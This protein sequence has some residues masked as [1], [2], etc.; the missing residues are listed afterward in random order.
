M[1]AP[2]ILSITIKFSPLVSPAYL[3]PELPPPFI[4]L[5][6]HETDQW[7]LHTIT[8]SLQWDMDQEFYSSSGI[9]F[10]SEVNEETCSASKPSVINVIFFSMPKLNAFQ[11]LITHC[12]F[13]S[14]AT[15]LSNCN[16]KLFPRK[17]SHK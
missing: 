17:E 8:E 3:P 15:R 16:R 13:L 4:Y 12:S 2:S 7:A 11:F 1:T 14:K 5:F 6:N 10:T 9:S